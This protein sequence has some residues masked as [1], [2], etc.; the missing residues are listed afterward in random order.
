MNKT[1]D[2]IVK[3]E[4]SQ[5]ENTPQHNHRE[6][7]PTK[8]PNFGLLSKF[9]PDNKEHIPNQ[10]LDISSPLSQDQDPKQESE[11]IIG[12]VIRINNT[13]K[14]NS[15][16]AIPLEIHD[17]VGNSSKAQKTT[18]RNNLME[19]PLFKDNKNRQTTESNSNNPNSVFFI[20]IPQYLIIY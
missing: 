20:H 2:Q 15:P 19:T 5:A 1:D 3:E 4:N 12:N 14:F 8:I 18:D 17:I 11:K 13:M 16:P 10:S 9:S 6:R 7:L